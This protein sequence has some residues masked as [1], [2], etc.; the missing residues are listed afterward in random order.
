MVKFGNPLSLYR[1]ISTTN[2]LYHC[3]F[4]VWYSKSYNIRMLE[5]VLDDLTLS[6]Y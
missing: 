4:E 5:E 3:P 2:S 6:M 1:F